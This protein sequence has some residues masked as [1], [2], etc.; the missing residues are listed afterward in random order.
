MSSFT[1]MTSIPAIDTPEQF[2]QTLIQMKANV[3]IHDLMLELKNR[4]YPDVNM[5][6]YDDLAQYVGRET[7]FCIDA[8]MFYKYSKISVEGYEFDLDTSDPNS[9]IHRTLNRSGMQ[10]DKDYR[11]RHVAEQDELPK[12][13]GNNAKRY[14]MNPESFYL[15]LMDIPDR[16]RASRRIFC[17]YHSFLTKVI[18]YYNDFQIGLKDLLDEEK[19]RLIA[20]K[21]DKI[22][23]LGAKIDS[24]NEKID[25]QNHK[26]DQ[27]HFIK[28]VFLTK[29]N[30]V[31]FCKSKHGIVDRA[32]RV[33]MALHDWYI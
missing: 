6:L 30:V 32:F 2:I 28:S 31:G 7:E 27:L 25:S 33:V 24:Q 4:F 17:R 13:G 8:R 10:I 14:M 1:N 21:D 19:N 23:I 16:Y 3:L 20:M 18:K 29:S 15:L 9:D 26:I 22:D 11:L 5:I 12:H